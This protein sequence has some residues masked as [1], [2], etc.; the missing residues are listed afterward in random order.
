M[1]VLRWPREI[2]C[3]HPIKSLLEKVSPNGTRF[4]FVK[5]IFLRTKQGVLFRRPRCLTKQKIQSLESCW[6]VQRV[7]L[8]FVFVFVVRK[9][10]PYLMDCLFSLADL[11]EA[12]SLPTLDDIMSKRDNPEFFNIL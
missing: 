2:G 1:T 12:N 9:G 7:I 3:S 5:L 4:V 8:S 6:A 10:W 11:L